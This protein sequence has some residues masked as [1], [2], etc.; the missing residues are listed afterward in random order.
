MKYNGI[1]DKDIMWNPE[2]SII[3][4]VNVTKFRLI[5]EFNEI[6][7]ILSATLALSCIISLLKYNKK[8]IRIDTSNKCECFFKKKILTPILKET[9]KKKKQ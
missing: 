9:K 1:A 4:N 7:N 3:N 8:Y 2:A 5:I 6:K